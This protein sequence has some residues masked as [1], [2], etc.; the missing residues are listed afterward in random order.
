MMLATHSSPGTT[1]ESAQIT[2]FAGAPLLPYRNME[3]FIMR[4]K[5]GSMALIVGAAYACLNA[6]NAYGQTA[7][8]SPQPATPERPSGLPNGRL[9]TLGTGALVLGY[10]PAFVVALTSDHKGDKDLFIPVVGPWFDLGDRVCTLTE[11]TNC[12]ATG[13]EKAALVV[14]GIVQGVGALM[15][16]GSFVIPER[17]KPRAADNSPRVR[18]VPSSIGGR[19]AGMSVFGQF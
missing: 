13:M 10:A 8:T 5:L 17:S 2:R 3:G 7:M 1:L 12:G 14:D 9:L 16:A 6:S 19:G 15:M 11:T 4:F 18:V